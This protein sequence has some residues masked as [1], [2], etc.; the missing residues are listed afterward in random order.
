LSEGHLV[1]VVVPAYNAQATLDETLQSVREQTHRVLEI[2]VVDD[3]STDGTRALAERHAAVDPR[4][5]VLHQPN[6]GVAAARNAGWQRAR[7]EFIAFVDADDLWAPAKIERQLALLQTAGDEVGLVYC[8][9]SKIDAAGRIAIRQESPLY[10][11]DVLEAIIGSN[12]IG[13]GSSVLMRRDA[14]LAAGGF[15][16]GLQAQG[17][18]GCEDYLLYYRVA[19]S[20]RFALLAQRLVGYRD[21]PHNM[22]SNRPRMLRSWLLVQGEIL[23]DHPERARAVVRSARDYTAW[24]LGDAMSHRAWQQVAPLLWTLG[25][26]HPGSALR[27]LVK[28][29]LRAAAR[30]LIPRRAAETMATERPTHFRSP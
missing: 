23:K 26:R 2:I 1:S 9:H 17:A 28:H 4:V 13:N 11:G 12:F 3:G 18:Q 25:R 20:R 24:L 8:W 29:A 19:A 14:L 10:E 5:V 30:R 27:V 7:S 21:L 6:A 16:A 15:D 22:S